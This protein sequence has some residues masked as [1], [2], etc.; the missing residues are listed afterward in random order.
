MGALLPITEK[1][2]EDRVNEMMNT[3]NLALIENLKKS[4][5][6]YLFDKKYEKMAKRLKH[7]EES[8]HKRGHNFDEE[9]NHCFETLNF[10]KTFQP[11]HSK[12]LNYYVDLK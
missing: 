5:K 9:I 8:L 7:I 3:K 12:S 4:T 2:D 1:V 10:T 6:E 11:N